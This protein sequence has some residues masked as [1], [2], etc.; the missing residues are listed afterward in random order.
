MRIEF[1]GSNGQTLADA[2]NE[3]RNRGRTIEEDDQSAILVS[4]TF[5]GPA[6]SLDERWYDGQITPDRWRIPV[7]Y[8]LEP[9]TGEVTNADGVVQDYEELIK[10]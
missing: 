6:L 10:L 9:D 1:N 5:P 3:A 4:P 2:L 8:F 7:G